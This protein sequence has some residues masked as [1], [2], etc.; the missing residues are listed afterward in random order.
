VSPIFKL[1]LLRLSKHGDVIK[2]QTIKV[3]PPQNVLANSVPDWIF[4]SYC[5]SSA[6]I[7]DIMK[8]VENLQ[9]WH[10]LA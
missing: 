7:L 6:D 9:V 3:C 4:S 2:T 8:T 10:S 5:A 1:V